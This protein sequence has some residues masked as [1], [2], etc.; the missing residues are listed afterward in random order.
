MATS[1][2]LTFDDLWSLR[3]MGNL[4]LSPDGRRVALVM[5][6]ADKVSNETR[7][8]IWLLHLD[9]HG[10]AAGEPR[11]LTG[12]GK[13]D[14]YPVWS[15][16]SRHLLFLSNRE[17]A[18][19]QLWLIDTDGGE[20]YKLTSMLHGVSEAAW[21]PDGRWIAFTAAVGPD[22][23]DDVLTGRKTLDEE[24]RKRYEE[25]QHFAPRRVRTIWYRV[26]GR[27]LF[28]QYNQL[29]IMPAPVGNQAVDPA[30]IRRLTTGDFDHSQPLWTP[31][32]QEVG[33]LCN[34]SENRDRSFVQDLWAIDHNMAEARCL[35]EGKLVII[36]YAW[37]P[38]GRAAV[39]VGGEG[40]ALYGRSSRL[41]LVTRRGNVGDR[42]LLLTP[43][44]EL[45]T[46]PVVGGES[47]MP[48]PYRPVWSWDGQ[49]LYFLATAR[50][51]VNV[52]CMDLVWRT[53]EAVTE[54]IAVN[55]FLALLPGE[56]GLLLAKEWADHLWELY[57]LTLNGNAGGES[58]RLTHCYDQCLA[59]FQWART[60]HIRYQGADGDE[61]DGWLTYPIG[62]REDVRYPL[63]VRIH[64]GPHAAFSCGLAPLN[65]YFAAQG[66]AVFYCNPHGSTGHDE[67]FMRSVLGD[68]GGRAF[69]DIMLGVDECI[70]RGVAD[71]ERMAITGYSY[72]GYMTMLA[73]G[74]TGRFKAAVAM[75]GISDLA[76]FVGTS[77]IGFWMVTQAQGY[78]WDPERAAYYR[79]HSPLTYAAQVSTPTLFLHPE[80]DLRCPI[81]Q[82]ERFYMTLKMLGHVPVEL[83]RMPQAWHTGTSKPNQWLSYWQM[84]LEWLN[85]YI[86][87][88]PGEYS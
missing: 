6:M 83:V 16:D 36:S 59:E 7:S 39:V 41:H 67:A 72:G 28:E 62:A 34:R 9:E 2:K 53:L 18:K 51:C 76:S 17:G 63:L 52:Y 87:I 26:D 74:Q 54:D 25:Q 88:R 66:Y 13:N 46:A 44:F 20:P 30:S 24:A 12:G 57:R 79:E 42:V 19:N 82:S 78:P 21:S 80:N 70:A 11:Q 45:A 22:D 60:E 68:W 61:I 8:A 3:S 65:H 77:D 15:P 48:G 75:A 43:D 4:A 37:S 71:P 85:K 31:D 64:G 38:D 33:V 32:S 14:T 55:S 58:E 47:G 81:E 69:Q 50:G 27:G 23:E 40:D 73:I 1:R 10:Y 49:H 5:R 84:M 56:Q 86:E 29:F 35:T